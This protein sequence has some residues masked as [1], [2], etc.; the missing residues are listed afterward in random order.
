MVV[1]IDVGRGLSSSAVTVTS[2][3]ASAYALT[4]L[5]GA[6][7]GA[8]TQ[9]GIFSLKRIDALDGLRGILAALV[10]IYHYVT[11]GSL[12]VPAFVSGFLDRGAIYAVIGFFVLSGVSM[13]V[14]YG[15][16]RTGSARE[17]AAFFI[18]RFFRIAPLF[19]LVMAFNLYGPV[20][21]CIMG[22][23]S[24]LDIGRVVAN[25]AF[26]FGFS[27]PARSSLVVA[28]WSIGIEW[29]FYAL[30]PIAVALVALAPK[31]VSALL[32]ALGFAV[33]VA[34]DVLYGFRAPSWVDY[35][36]FPAY[37][38]YFAFG[39]WAAINRA[40]LSWSNGMALMTV[41]ALAFFVATVAIKYDFSNSVHVATAEAVLFGAVTCL[42]V[43]VAASTANP[44]E[45]IARVMRW[46][47]EMSFGVYLL[48]FPVSVVVA[49]Q[50]LTGWPAFIIACAITVAA[51]QVIFL[52]V[53]KPAMR[54]GSA[55]SKAVKRQPSA[56]VPA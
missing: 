9:D 4:K 50:G 11:W 1:S 3:E 54:I 51:A 8:V 34:W 29:V 23:C 49:K 56:T 15:D 37:A 41:I 25:G 52:L 14:A 32:C 30:F 7:H 19:Y 35:A 16:M 43:Y 12:S 13:Y 28:G 31:L 53:E 47:G 27:A 10:V 18:K 55:L 22:A 48:H 6:I 40:T 26:V 46:L 38:F 36:Q 39:I 45:P 17:V 5:A 21:Q 33:L 42:A 20:K 24:G 2:M 44:P